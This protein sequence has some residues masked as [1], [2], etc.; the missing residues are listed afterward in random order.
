MSII[1]TCGSW[2]LRGSEELEGIPGSFAICTVAPGSQRIS[3]ACS[4]HVLSYIP[5]APFVEFDL[6]A[7]VVSPLG[8]TPLAPEV[9]G[10]P[11]GDMVDVDSLGAHL[12]HGLRMG[13]DV[14]VGVLLQV[15]QA[16][17]ELLATVARDPLCSLVAS[18]LLPGA[19]E[20]PVGLV[21]L[22]VEGAHPFPFTRIALMVSTTSPSVSAMTMPGFGR[23]PWRFVQ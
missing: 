3:R 1:I 8:L 15:I 13:G 23:L 19:D 16:V 5:A 9:L 7:V 20:G 6:G 2:A 11:R 22:E 18:C 10:D 12:R 4:T 21:D 17:G 14:E